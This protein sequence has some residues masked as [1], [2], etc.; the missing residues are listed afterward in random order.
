MY[1]DVTKATAYYG[2]GF[3]Q[4]ADLDDDQKTQSL[5]TA[6]MILDAIYGARFPGQ[7]TGGLQQLRQWPRTNA[8]TSSGEVIPTELVPP[9]VEIATFEIAK[10][11]IV[12]PGRI[13]PAAFNAQQV[14]RQKI[15]VLEREFFKN[16]SQDVRT[17]LPHLPIIEGI[18]I[19]LISD[20]QGM[21]PVFWVR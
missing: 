17:N 3:P 20:M 13:L 7:K 19:E 14:K 18:L 16:Q 8:R 4:W 9:A 2:T 6:S 5:V 12:R 21:F 15:D 1:G 11:E 10:Q